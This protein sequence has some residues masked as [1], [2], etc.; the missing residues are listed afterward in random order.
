LADIHST[1]QA[2]WTPEA[3]V[4]SNRMPGDV[5]RAYWLQP[6]LPEQMP[7]IATQLLVDGH[8]TPSLC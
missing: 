1:P 5:A 2:A 3:A 4:T 7:D 6:L 8:D